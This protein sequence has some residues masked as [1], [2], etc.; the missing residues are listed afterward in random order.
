MQSFLKFSFL[1]LTFLTSLLISGSSYAQGIIGPGTSTAL[2]IN[3]TYEYKYDI[4]GLSANYTWSSNAG[5]VTSQTQRDEPVNGT[6][7]RYS[8]ANIMMNDDNPAL[9]KSV[10]LNISTAGGS[11]TVSLGIYVKYVAAPEV[12]SATPKS[13][14]CGTSGSFSANLY[15]LTS[16]TSYQ[17]SYSGSLSGPATTTDRYATVNYNASGDGSFTVSGVNNAGGCIH[18]GRSTTF[19]ITRTPSPANPAPGVSATKIDLCDA[20][21][22]TIVSITNPNSGYSYKWT[23]TGGAKLNDTQT[24]VTTVGG[25]SVKVTATANGSVNVI[26]I[27]STCGP[28]PAQTITVFYG[29]GVT[30]S[31]RLQKPSALNY[32]LQA[33][34]SSCPGEILG[35]VFCYTATS[36]SVSFLGGTV[37]GRYWSTSPYSVQVSFT[38]PAYGSAGFIV[39]ANTACGQISTTHRFQSQSNCP[40]FRMASEDVSNPYL[41]VYPNPTANELTISYNPQTDQNK[42][43]TQ[44]EKQS[45]SFKVELLNSL[46]KIVKIA[47]N[48]EKGNKIVLNVAQLPTGIYFLQVVDGKVVH[49]QKVIIQH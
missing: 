16:A 4:T 30:G 11:Q 7:K 48:S 5:T 24:E 39:T 18:V 44:S 36:M 12:T 22:S 49:K 41:V 6:T 38:I 9:N 10:K 23:A 28:S 33:Y 26:A 45:K 47:S 29:T 19:Q 46:G 2:C 1:S 27:S 17:W 35:D 25:G 32:S 14:V 42:L 13:I 40:T 21:K 31:Y 15:P 43:E 3:K 20:L 34:Q 8:V 37:N